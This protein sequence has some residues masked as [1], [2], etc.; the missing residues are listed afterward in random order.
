LPRREQLYAVNEGSL[1][2]RPVLTGGYLMETKLMQHKSFVSFTLVT[3]PL[4]TLP[5]DFDATIS[6]LIN[7]VSP[8]FFK[9]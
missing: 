2:L 8:V 4:I 5:L 9:R 1:I 7:Q 6:F 3:K